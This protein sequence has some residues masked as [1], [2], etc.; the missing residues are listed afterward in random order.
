MSLLV[1]Y[2]RKLTVNPIIWPCLSKFRLRQM[3]WNPVVTT[4]NRYAF[5]KSRALSGLQLM[6]QK[7]YRLEFN[8]NLCRGFKGELFLELLAAQT[9]Q[10]FWSIIEF[11]SS[12][13]ACSNKTKCFIK[14][15]SHIVVYVFRILVHTKPAFLRVEN[16]RAW[17]HRRMSHLVVHFT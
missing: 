10:K 4:A 8:L 2:D 13:K 9:R 12:S 11:H 6:P 7:W 15:I 16:L 5:P 17:Q 3:E 1:G 14:T